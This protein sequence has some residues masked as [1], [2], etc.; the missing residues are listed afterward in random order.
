MRD[1]SHSTP[2]IFG[3]DYQLRLWNF[4]KQDLY[5]ILWAQ[6]AQHYAFS[7]Q[8]FENESH[9]ENVNMCFQPEAKE[10]NISFGTRLHIPNSNYVQHPC[11]V[12][13]C[14]RTSLFIVCILAS[15]ITVTSFRRPFRADL[16]QTHHSQRPMNPLPL[17]RDPDP[18]SN[19]NRHF[20]QIT[21]HQKRTTILD[22]TF[23]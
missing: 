4:H 13:L 14:Y 18:D 7:E 5:F 19:A 20:K 12:M 1:P 22:I 2:H 15:D 23:Y 9:R 10:V 3:F 6:C 17:E 11:L 16:S 21:C 8:K